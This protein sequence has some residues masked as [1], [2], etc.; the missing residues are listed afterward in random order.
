MTETKSQRLTGL[1]SDFIRSSPDV[2]AAAV[3]SPDGLVM[4][5]VLPPDM[6]EDRLGAMSTALL[7]LGEQT[8]SGLGRG[9][10]SQ[11]FV[12]GKDGFVLLM[13]AKD[14]AVLAVVTNRAAKIGFMLFEVCRAAEA[15]GTWLTEP[16]EYDI[17]APSADVARLEFA[18]GVD[19][20]IDTDEQT[21]ALLEQLVNGQE[22]RFVVG[23]SGG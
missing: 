1:L 10:V 7:S 5:S 18:A 12:E 2:E 13:S 9:S 14:Q 16:R 3:V 11:L 22:P 20:G 8:A 23:P 21:S 19:A 4:A 17:A 15:I 6:D